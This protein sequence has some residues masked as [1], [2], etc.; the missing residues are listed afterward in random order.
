MQASV[1]PIIAAKARLNEGPSIR[2][3]CCAESADRERA[4][5]SGARRA[6]AQLL[7]T[8]SCQTRA[9][10]RLLWDKTVRITPGYRQRG[11]DATVSKVGLAVM[12]GPNTV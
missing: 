12:R 5:D 2:D 3:G 7:S 10:L 9:P 6:A 1:R 11:V 8:S 4:S